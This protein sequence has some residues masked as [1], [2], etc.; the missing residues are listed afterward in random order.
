MSFILKHRS[1]LLD[2]TRKVS[3]QVNSEEV[4]EMNIRLKE[5]RTMYFRKGREQAL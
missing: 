1:S 5:G 2:A 4:G 3:L